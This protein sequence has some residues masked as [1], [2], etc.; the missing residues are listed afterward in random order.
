M[1]TS[2]SGT[3]RSLQDARGSEA[4]GGEITRRNGDPYRQLWLV[5]AVQMLAMLVRDRG[6]RAL[7]HLGVAHLAR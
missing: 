5:A 7:A 2:R 4:S 1:P 3:G 6:G